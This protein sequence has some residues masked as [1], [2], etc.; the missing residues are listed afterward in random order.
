MGIQSN[1][2]YLVT[3]CETPKDLWDTLKA[4]FE[5][6]TIANKLFL[7]RQYFTS[8][9]LEGQ[10]AQDHLQRMKEIADKLHALGPTV[11]EEEQVVALL[12]S[13]PPSYTTLVTALR[14]K[15]EMSFH[16]LSSSKPSSMKS[17]KDRPPKQQQRLKLIET[18]HYTWK[19]A[20]AGLSKANVTTVARRFIKAL[21][22]TKGSK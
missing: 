4:Y 21:N 12:I 19:M 3:S 16:Y 9:M 18:Q 10:S 17:R 8:K 14:A 15:E 2:I 11:D 20:S 22:V 13:L 6:D 5:R 1:L 7:K